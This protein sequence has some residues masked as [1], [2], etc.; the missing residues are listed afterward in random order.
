MSTSGEL[1]EQLRG[2]LEAW[3]R[4]PDGWEYIGDNPP[5]NFFLTDVVS[6]C[7]ENGDFR[8]GTA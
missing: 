7:D 2:F 1:T 4:T 8:Q 3:K 5:P 6:S